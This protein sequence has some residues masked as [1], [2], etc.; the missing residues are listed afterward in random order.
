MFYLR[1]GDGDDSDA[2]RHCLWAALIAKETDVSWAK[3]WTDAH[4]D[5]TDNNSAS[6]EM[7]IY[8][9]DKGIRIVLENPEISS[10]MIIQSCV[11]L[12]ENGELRIIKK[13]KIQ[14][15]SL[16]GF[17]VPNIFRVIS[18]KLNDVIEFITSFH[19][20][21]A[22]ETD[23][24]GNTALHRCIVSD[25][26]EGFNILV[27]FLDV[28]RP[29]MDGQSP[30]MLCST[31]SHG[32]KYAKTLLDQGA[33][34]NYQDPHYGETA[35]MLAAAYGRREIVNLLLP[36]TNKRI[37]SFS[38]VTAYDMAVNEGNMEIAK[39]LI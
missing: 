11:D 15:T 10:V 25:Y 37:K 36:V 21:R 31:L 9:N 34:A 38:G 7:D 8:N 3:R 6:R 2:F 16:N 39:S 23:E 20:T 30:L 4:E 18:E 35:L 19:T 12:I 24:D 1:F 14:P 28:N 26:E 33:I 13:G 17:N 27:R 5:T 29:G 22:E 32:Y